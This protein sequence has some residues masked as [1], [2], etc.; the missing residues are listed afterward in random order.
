MRK[1]EK[2]ILEKTGE[3]CFISQMTNI[4]WEE[5]K[6]L[7]DDSKLIP[8]QQYRITDY[9]TTV[10]PNMENACS[11]GHKFDIIVVADNENT[12]NEKARAINHPS[13]IEGAI[14]VKVVEENTSYI[15][16]RTP[17]FD[18]N[19][20]YA[21]AYVNDSDYKDVCFVDLEDY[22][23][24]DVI[25]TNTLTPNIGDI[26]D[27]GGVNV[28]LVSIHYDA[29]YFLTC[30]LAAWELWYCLDNDKSSFDWA[31]EENGTGV[32]YRMI[33]EWGND[34]PYDF[35]N[36]QFKRDVYEEG[37]LAESGEEDYSLW[38]YTFS[39]RGENGEVIDASIFGNYGSLIDQEDDAP[40]V[41]NNIM[42]KCRDRDYDLENTTRVTQILNNN[43]FFACYEYDYGLL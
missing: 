12:L 7:R 6:T 26:L 42:G 28:E 35:K 1:I 21:W 11:A 13:I 37:G 34:C 2:I 16:V 38:C 36:I 33:D 41:Y 10:D 25:F 40:G 43:V 5:L 17:E 32:I 9:V 29:N 14:K 8:G 4:T 19:D 23:T 39:F 20:M 30:N 3:E 18:S 24:A 31:D 22:D 15:Y 27:M